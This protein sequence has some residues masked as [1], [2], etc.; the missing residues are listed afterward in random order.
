MPNGNAPEPR[1]DRNNEIYDDGKGPRR[2]LDRVKKRPQV[3]RD[4]FRPRPVRESKRSRR[5]DWDDVYDDELDVDF[6]IDEDEDDEEEEELN[7]IE[8]RIPRK[9][10]QS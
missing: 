4:D 1:K 6:D 10:Q 8:V 9:R 3:D 5:R 7:E 2:R